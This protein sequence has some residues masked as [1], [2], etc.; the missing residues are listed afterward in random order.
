MLKHPS[1]QSS[2]LPQQQSQLP[3]QQDPIFSY[4]PHEMHNTNSIRIM[5][6]PKITG[7][8]IAMVVESVSLL[9]SPGLETL[10][11]G[12]GS[13]GPVIIHLK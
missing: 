6:D 1:K 10:L 2:R 11:P 5:A 13:K 12:S 4:H 3:L 9:V 7:S 8:I